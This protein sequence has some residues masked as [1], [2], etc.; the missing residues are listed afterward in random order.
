MLKVIALMRR[1]PGLT[2]AQFIEYYETRHAPLMNRLQQPELV[3]YKRNFVDLEGAILTDGNPPW[4]DV[5]TELYYE[6]RQAY[7][8]CMTR[9][10]APEPTQQRIADESNFLDRSMIHFFIVEEKVT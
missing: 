6:S 4:F 9:L 2:K 10:A 3:G 7:E 5:V 8:Q 1:K